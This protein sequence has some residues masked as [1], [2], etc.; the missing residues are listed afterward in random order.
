M[1]KKYK[2]PTNDEA[3]LQVL[4]DDITAIGVATYRDS[5]GYDTI[6]EDDVEKVVSRRRGQSDFSS[7]KAE[8]YANIQYDENGDPYVP[9]IETMRQSTRRAGGYAD[10]YVDLIND[11]VDLTDIIEE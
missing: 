3:R 6:V 7:A 9:H 8:T 2:S 5:L 4:I 11:T 1:Y 10:V